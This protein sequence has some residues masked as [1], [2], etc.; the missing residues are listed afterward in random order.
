MAGDRNPKQWSEVAAPASG[1]FLH[2]HNAAET[3]GQRTKWSDAAARLRTLAAEQYVVSAGVIM[4]AVSVDR[5]VWFYNPTARQAVGMFI[6]TE[7]APTGSAIQVDV[8]DAAAAKQSRV[9]SLAAAANREFTAFGS[10][11]TLGA[12]T[13]W[14]AEVIQKGSDNAGSWLQI[15]IIVKDT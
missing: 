13:I 9:G 4:G 6:W 1:A 15:Q 14:G 2:G 8:I 3:A 11:L 10:A 7:D 5:R 12:A